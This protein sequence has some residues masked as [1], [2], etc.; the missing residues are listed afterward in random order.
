MYLEIPYEIGE[1]DDVKECFDKLELD[2]EDERKEKVIKI[3]SF[4]Y[5]K[6]KEYT[7]VKFHPFILYFTT[8]FEAYKTDEDIKSIIKDISFKLARYDAQ[9]ESENIS[10]RCNQIHNASEE[11]CNKICSNMK[12]S[13][14]QDNKIDI[15]VSENTK[16]IKGYSSEANFKSYKKTAENISEP[17]FRKILKVK[18]GFEKI[19]EFSGKKIPSTVRTKDSNVSL[20]FIENIVKRKEINL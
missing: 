14:N 13:L 6:I 8:F 19:Y 20:E 17:I 12:N 16:F 4:Y 15:F 2:I 1:N 7:N 10:E 18:D 3:T 11:K 5:N 9:R